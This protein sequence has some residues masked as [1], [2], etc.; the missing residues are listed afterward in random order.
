MV[1]Y[2]CLVQKTNDPALFEVC[3]SK[4]MPL[5]IYYIAVKTK[6]VHIQLLNIIIWM[7]FASFYPITHYILFLMIHLKAGDEMGVVSTL[8]GFQ[9]YLDCEYSLGQHLSHLHD[10][11]TS[12][13]DNGTGVWLIRLR[14]THQ[15]FGQGC[16]EKCNGWGLFLSLNIDI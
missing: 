12:V 10:G 13:Q 7:L 5:G 14:W 1:L 4:G 8:S 6:F 3:S 16:E 9:V 15:D 11:R 2:H